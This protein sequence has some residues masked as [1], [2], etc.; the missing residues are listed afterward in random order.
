MVRGSSSGASQAGRA[1]RPPVPSPLPRTLG[2]GEQLEGLER[3]G[4]RHGVVLG[5]AD[6]HEERV[7]GADAGVVQ[8]ARGGRSDVWVWCA[9]VRAC[10][11]RARARALLEPASRSGAAVGQAA[12]PAAAARSQRLATRAPRADGV[13]V[14]DL[15]LL[16]LQQVT[17]GAVQHAG[18]ALG[19]RGRV[20]LG[21][22]ALPARLHAHQPHLRRAGAAGA[23]VGGL[24][25]RRPAA[26]A[27][28]RRRLVASASP[29]AFLATHCPSRPGPRRSSQPPA[30][31]AARR[32]NPS[33][34]SPSSSRWRRAHLPVL[35]K[36]VEDAD[37]VGAA[38]H[39]RH[40]HVG[41]A[42]PLVQALLP[43]LAPDDCA[44]GRGGGGRVSGPAAA[45]AAAAPAAQPGKG[46]RAPAAGVRRTATA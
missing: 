10:R 40:D 23:R 3:L 16:V 17:H 6:V 22:D 15:P 43:G 44:G 31:A 34:S 45:A 8:A 35:H 11:A 24:R 18:R 7:L 25:R 37:G 14:D 27:P 38:A 13:R 20:L 28:Y 29:S 21:V 19:Q 9:I 4:I 42:A 32:S 26:G 2:L 12:K 5:A 39:A 1:A 36:L 33:P 41:L 30:A 46:R